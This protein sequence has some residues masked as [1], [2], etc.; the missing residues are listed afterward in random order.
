MNVSNVMAT[1]AAGEVA[2]TRPVGNSM[3]PLIKSGQE[4]VIE[5]VNDPDSLAVGD[6]VFALVKGTYYLHLISAIRDDKVQISNA[7]GFVNGWTNKSKV[8]GRVKLP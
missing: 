4:V 3:L 8:F 1:L 6:I 7:K 2:Y 5:P